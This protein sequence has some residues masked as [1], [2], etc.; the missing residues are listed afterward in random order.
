[1]RETIEQRH[2]RSSRLCRH[3]GSKL[4]GSW[5][6]SAGHAIDFYSWVF[7]SHLRGRIAM[8]SKQL[9]DHHHHEWSLDES[10]VLVAL[11]MDEELCPLEYDKETIRGRRITTEDSPSMLSPEDSF[12]FLGKWSNSAN[13]PFDEPVDR[14]EPLDV[15]V[16][17]CDCPCFGGPAFWLPF[18]WGFD[19]W[20]FPCWPGWLGSVDGRPCFPCWWPWPWP[21]P[22]CFPPSFSIWKYRN[23]GRKLWS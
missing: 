17:D 5:D 9:I 2:E 18:S 23:Y 13:R 8:Q 21:C 16:F 7:Y 19:W 10:S 11:L 3:K 14:L 20:S 6:I 15:F 4:P 12:T 1:M 22:C